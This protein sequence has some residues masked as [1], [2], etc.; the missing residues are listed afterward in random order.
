MSEFL[1]KMISSKAQ[2]LSQLSLADRATARDAAF[3]ALRKHKPHRFVEALSRRDRVNIIAEVKRSSPSVGSIRNDADVVE[4]AQAYARGGAAAVSVLTEPNYFGG[5]LEDLQLA[6]SA[7]QIPVLRKDFI[8]D[9]HQIF[10]AAARGASAVL[11]IVAALPEIR[12]REL[13]GVAQ[14]KLGLDALVE[15]HTREELELAVKCGAR[16]IGVN[17]RNLLTLE[18]SLDVSRELAKHAPEHV[19]LVSESGIRTSEQI[20]ELRD[21]GYDAFLVGES[22]MRSSQPETAVRSLVQAEVAR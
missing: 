21:L 7:V 9:E 19:T 3:E 20:A 16:I 2:E 13:L 6:A 22:L 17:N 8:V 12:L 10:E 14:Q 4:T 11:L 1:S 5:T 18:V 15:V